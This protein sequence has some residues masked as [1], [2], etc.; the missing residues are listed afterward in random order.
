MESERDNVLLPPRLAMGKVTR[1]TNFLNGSN[2]PSI[3]RS[4]LAV[5]IQSC[6]ELCRRFLITRDTREYKFTVVYNPYFSPN[7]TQALRFNLGYTSETYQL[8]TMLE[9]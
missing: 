3:L 2:V 7:K 8:S 4:N 9:T 1:R 5:Y 6:K